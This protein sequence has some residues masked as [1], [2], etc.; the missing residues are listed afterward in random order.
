LAGA[1]VGVI[2]LTVTV[3][4]PFLAIIGEGAMGA[5]DVT[6]AHVDGSGEELLDNL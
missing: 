2:F 3:A 4:T 5:I 6:P 1:S